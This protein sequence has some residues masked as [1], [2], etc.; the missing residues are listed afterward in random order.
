M[1]RKFEQFWTLRSPSERKFLL[2]WSALLI[3]ALAYFLLLSP[4]FQRIGLLQKSIPVLETQ[5]FAMR[6]QPNVGGGKNISSVSAT[7]DLRSSLFRLLAN[8]QINADLRSISAKRIELRLPEMPAAEALERLDK[9]RQ[10]A[11]ARIVALSI[12]ASATT[13]LVQIILEMERDQ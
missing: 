3:G 2:A 12:K 13:N 8:Q 11:A 5:L 9:L 6:A 10:E 4:L 1:K 7:E